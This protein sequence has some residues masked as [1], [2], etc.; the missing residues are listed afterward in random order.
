VAGY[1]GGMRIHKRW[2]EIICPGDKRVK[3]IGGAPMW[4][5][6][7]PF[8]IVRKNCK[9]CGSPVAEHILVEHDGEKNQSI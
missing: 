7:T 3:T 6:A 5:V 1:I 4:K 9:K 2:V 8:H